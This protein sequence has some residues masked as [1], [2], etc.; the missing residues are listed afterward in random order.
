MS[1]EAW[2]SLAVLGASVA[3]MAR[4]AW[5]PDLVLVAAMTILLV[6]G[7]ITPAE[8]AAGF[9]NEGMLTIAALLVVAAGVESTRAL[10]WIVARVLA[11]P[12][13]VTGA[14]ARVMLP[15]AV[16]S[17]LVNNT[18]VVAM[19]LP[20]VQSWSRRCQISVSKLLLPLS[21]AAILGGTL[22]LIGTSANLVVTGLAVERYPDLTWSLF[23]ITPIGLLVAA[24]GLLYVLVAAR[25]LLPTRAQQAPSLDS[26]RDYCVGFRVAADAPIIGETIEDAGLRHLPGL[27][28]AE[29]D[30]DGETLAAVPPDTRLRAG[31]LLVFVGVLESVMDLRK[32]RGLRPTAHDQVRKLGIRSGDR[33][34]VEAVI[35]LGSALA[36]TSVRDAAF[37]TRYRA[38]IIAVHRGGERLTGKIGDVVL[39]FGDTLLL[40]AHSSF[41]ER[42]RDDRSFALVHPVEGSAPVRHERGGLVLLLLAAMVGLTASGALS[43]LAAA[44]AC[45][46]AM[47]VSRCLTATEARRALDVGLLLTIA[48]SLALGQALVSSGAAQAL[49]DGIVAAAAPFGALGVLVG[50]YLA[51]TLLTEM[52]S[53]TAAAALLFPVAMAA[54]EAA[55]I[56]PRPMCYVVMFAASASFM[57][58]LGYPTNL[59]VYGPGGYRF[60][61]YLRFGAPM[62]LLVGAVTVAA[63]YGWFV[64]P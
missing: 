16:M 43:M 26:A 46:V 9:A 15:T 6:L 2:A 60:A 56:A 22:T 45:G 21:W 49:A 42:H 20:L 51:V 24:V 1:W 23:E 41:L 62:Q 33:L 53:N 63:V 55:G 35:G 48:A 30:R 38:A 4:G 19:M 29:I 58:P 47:L 32:I 8:A 5:A 11:R 17:A 36:G 37:R 10:Q 13:S 44:L 50:V 64:A 3:A 52:I 18:P 14:Q 12:R 34:L 28:L 25:W 27:F 57:T 7:V 61:D 39:R 40:E 31:D 59:M 54:G